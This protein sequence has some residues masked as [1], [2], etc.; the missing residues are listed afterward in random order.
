MIF[1]A[2]A[3]CSICTECI[4]KRSTLLQPIPG[5]FSDERTGA[6]LRIRRLCRLRKDKQGKLR[7]SGIPAGSLVQE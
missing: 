3:C 4:V 5:K 1:N 2:S 6:S 7:T